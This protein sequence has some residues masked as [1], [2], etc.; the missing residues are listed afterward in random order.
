MNCP[1]CHEPLREGALFCTRCGAKTAYGGGA[2]NESVETAGRKVGVTTIGGD[3]PD[4]D[5]LVGR[6]L[7]GKYEI[8]APLGTG[9][10]GAVYRARRVHIGD[11]VAVKILHQRLTSDEKLVERFRRE[12][13]A[14]A[15]LHHPQVVTIHDYG[16]ARGADGFAYIVMELVRGVSLRELLRREGRLD[17]R[18]AVSL[19]RDVCA[20]V[21]AAHRR[22]IVHRDIKPDNIIVTPADEDRPAESVKVVDFG[23]AK[24]R[25]MAAE[26]STLTEA[27]TMVGTL[28]YM[29]PE[30]CKGEPLD[31]R[32]DVYSLGAMLHE[33]LAGAPPFAASSMTSLV[34]KHVSAPP[35]P[36]PDD[37][38]VPPALRAAIMRALAKEPD[39]RPRDAS[40]FAREIQAALASDP[41][42]PYGASQQP[43]APFFPATARPAH[44]T[45]THP[46]PHRP[47]DPAREEETVVHAAAGTRPRH[48]PPPR[49]QQPPPGAYPP[50]ARRSRKG[51]FVGLLAVLLVGLAGLGVVGLLLYMNRGAG[52]TTVNTRPAPTP[53]ANASPSPTPTP[54][55]EPVQLAEVKILGGSLLSPADLAG[56]SP[57]YL[58][59][60]RNTTYARHGRTF[61][62][63]DLR[64]HFQSR[65]WYRPRPDFDE[66]KL[67]TNDRANADLLKAF[68]DN[69]GAPPRGDDERVERDVKDALEDWAESTRDRDLDAHMS[70][71]ADTLETFYRRQNVAGTIVRAERSR[72]FV[73]YDDMD[74][75]IENVR[76]TP[77]P[78]GLRAT[79]VFDKTWDFDSP[80]KNSRGSVR[81]QLT[82]VRAGGR[83]LINGERDLQVYYANSEGY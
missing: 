36:L 43:P 14:A 68:E 33:M 18:R 83:W 2:T 30:Q 45:P 60:L 22:G 61:Q 50:P 21:G 38:D 77:D 58:N 64:Q 44:V 76:V 79:V 16:E 66:R 5:P 34:I 67:T 3:P 74:V 31:S 7:D 17:A 39:E 71:Y 78:T 24:L 25:D 19:M 26:T 80:D 28:F 10:M 52:K 8:V 4:A 40:E 73:R 55:P 63:N 13:R 47:T 54:L 41:A 1:N 29:S 62:D 42:A 37:V 53:R 65:P 56:V 48:A 6:V 35:P 81:Q 20:G 75:K 12:A 46:A 27:G 69:D 70:R 32:A 59:R 82:L 15:Q 51:Y 23:I 9:G 11:E 49:G 57:A 72:A